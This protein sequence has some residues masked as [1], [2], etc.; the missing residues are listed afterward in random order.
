[1]KYLWN[2]WTAWNLYLIWGTIYVT[3]IKKKDQKGLFAV[4]H[5][6][7]AHGKADVHVV[8][9]HPTF[10]CR[11]SRLAHGEVFAV[12]PWKGSGQRRCLPAVDCRGRFA[13][14]NTA[15]AVCLR[16]TANV[17][18]PV[19]SSRRTGTREAK[20]DLRGHAAQ[21]YRHRYCGDYFGTG[22]AAWLPASQGTVHE[23]PQ[24]SWQYTGSHGDRWL[25]PSNE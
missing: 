21:L 22:W 23:F 9:R 14:C 6:V 3:G 25:W 1:M 20:G 17:R 15:F 16:H 18:P 2:I 19:V 24:V 4:C 12:C 8:C 11:A 13:V 10:F 5:A 7:R